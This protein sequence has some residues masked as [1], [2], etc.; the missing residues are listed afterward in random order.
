MMR[1]V[2]LLSM[3]DLDTSK[4]DITEENFL[5]KKEEV[6]AVY[7]AVG[8]VYCPY[9]QEKI[10]FNSKGLEHLKFKT[11]NHARSREDQYTRFRIFH[12]APKIITASKTIQ[13]ILH[14][15][16]FELVRTH[17]RTESVL[18]PVSYYEF[19]AIMDYKRVRVVV[20]Q[21]DDG[22]KYFWSVIPSWKKDKGRGRVMHSKGLENE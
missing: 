19:I 13:G 4:D 1:V 18:K 16:G 15:K 8:E 20:K 7:K 5:K 2:R 12:L 11:K 10:A 21:I 22:P 3:A 9:C 6:E 17:A 14:T